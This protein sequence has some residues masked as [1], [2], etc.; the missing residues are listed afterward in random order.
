MKSKVF[1][2]AVSV[3]FLIAS[4]SSVEAGKFDPLFKVI[5]VV[6]DCKVSSSE[7]GSFAAVVENKAYP[8]GSHIKTGRNSSIIIVLSEGNEVQVLGN[9]DLVMNEDTQDK[10]LKIIKLNEGQIEVNL[11]HEFSEN[12]GLNVETATAICAAIA[13]KFS[14]D[15]RTQDDMKVCIFGT[16]EGKVKLI[17]KH[18]TIPELDADD[19]VTLYSSFDREFLRLKVMKGGLSI[20][21]KDSSGN[22]QVIP[23]KLNSTIKIWSRRADVGNNVVVT[24]LITSP[25]GKVEHTFTYTEPD[26]RTVEDITKQRRQIKKDIDGANALI[27]AREEAEDEL[28]PVVTTTTTTTTT[29]TTT[30]IS[31]RLPGYH[32]PGSRQQEAWQ[33]SGGGGGQMGDAADVTPKGRR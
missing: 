6:G 24:I 9:A 13:C 21:L 10:K 4:Y 33:Q 19:W 22:A 8:Y 27:K 17:G 23:L 12:N 11:E 25:D 18:F 29:V 1:L 7:G 16:K 14:I 28:I 5:N 31:S 32:P 3:F 20:E 30:T 15:V 26:D 2:V